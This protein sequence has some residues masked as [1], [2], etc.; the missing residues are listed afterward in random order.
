[1]KIAFS[2]PFQ[3]N[4]ISR[5]VKARTKQKKNSINLFRHIVRLS[6]KLHR[7]EN[8]TST[9]LERDGGVQRSLLA[10]HGARETGSI[11]FLKHV[12]DEILSADASAHPY[13]RGKSF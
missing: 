2:P 12:Y 9:W 13:R 8:V 1:M 11:P 4:K 6:T 3:S 7:N 5:K 10:I